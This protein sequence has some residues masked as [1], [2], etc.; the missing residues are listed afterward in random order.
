MGNF[1]NELKLFVVKIDK[2]NPIKALQ[3]ILEL[4]ADYYYYAKEIAE[5]I[6][7]RRGTITGMVNDV[8][9][10]YDAAIGTF[11]LGNPTYCRD[12]KVEITNID[13]NLAIISIAYG[14]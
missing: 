3:K 2:K 7:E 11:L 12:F 14:V 1:I 9:N 4:D 8:I 13:D 6:A 10:Y 5:K